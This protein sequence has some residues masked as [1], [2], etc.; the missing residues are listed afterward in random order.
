M[1][2]ATTIA[3]F[4]VLAIVRT[5]P[6]D[7]IY[8]NDF[9]T[10]TSAAPVPS[11]DWR[12]VDYV[13]GL[14][15]NT[16]PAAP[17]AVSE[18]PNIQ[19]W[20]IKSQQAN[21][22][23]NA[24]V[25]D[26]FGN[27]AA[28]LGDTDAQH[29]SFCMVK[30]RLG[31]TFA[32][33]VVTVQFDFRPPA[34]WGAYPGNRRATLS[35]GDEGFY[36]PDVAQAKVY[37]H[38]VGSVGV[39]LVTGSGRRAYWNADKDNANTSPSDKA[40][41][42]G[43]WCRAVATIDLEARTWGFSL[44][45]MGAHP[46][47]DAPT[48][49]TAVESQSNLPF[50]DDAVTSISSIA[51]GGFG[52]CWS[53]AAYADGTAP[54]HVAAFD[55]IRVWH[56]GE[57]C[58][59]NDF[60]SSRR[61]SLGGTLSHAYVADCLVTNRV[62]SEVYVKQENLVPA[63]ENSGN[64]VQTP[65]IDGW[66]RTGNTGGADN[67]YVRDEIISGVTYTYLR[68]NSTGGG[69]Q[70]AFLAHPFGSTVSSGKLSLSVDA[71]IPTSWS[72]SAVLWVTLGNDDY[73]NASPGTANNHRWSAVGI[74]GTA[75][76]PTF[77]TPSG[78]LNPSPTAAI[79]SGHWYRIVVEADLDAG[80]TIYKLYEQGT[81]YPTGSAADGTLIYT[82]PAIA[83]INEIRLISSFS[84]GAYYCPVY[85][86]NVKVWHTA[87]GSSEETLLY[88]NDFSNRTYYHQD[89][90]IGKLA[91]T[92]LLNPAGQDGWSRLNT[93]AQDVFVADG[94]NP[95]L[96]FA[97]NATE[98]YAVHDLGQN[99]KTGILTAQADI[100]PPKGW[101]DVNGG[102]YVRLGGDAHATGSLRADDTNFLKNIAEGFGFKR[103]TGGKSGGV[104]TNSTI[105]AY[106]GDLAGGGAFEASSAQVD[107]THWYR[108]VATADMP[109]S[110]YDVAV[111]DM[112]AA[113]PTL[114][115]ATP[116]TPVATF[117]GLPFR[118][119]KRNLGGV[120][121]V[122]VCGNQTVWSTADDSLQPL[123]DNIRVSSKELAFVL[124]VR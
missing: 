24:R 60:S 33:G 11:Q 70:F 49:A 37:D 29:V 95:A 38:T 34:S 4:S 83:K 74:R 62:G 123:V 103:T 71:R 3:A 110:A 82:S 30:Q 44:Y 85:F 76:T 53:G 55:N 101:L 39:V 41:T 119:A 116:E 16:N 111:Y 120:S 93:S 96:S 81:A 59:E 22:T 9:A 7:T 52:V 58:Y 109:K 105:V 46:A 102:V 90:H 61:R 19:D 94:P 14:L 87:S 91:G 13:T 35:F 63:R 114:A 6:A 51:L 10:R 32:S 12:S 27:H 79:S 73:Y 78:A 88:E 21:N 113:Q 56:N 112:G 42:Q 15:A 50:A 121:C 65:G 99:V 118:R 54:T 68:F 48:P 100:R 115:S 47:F 28:V 84:L 17:L 23:G 18:M 40:V 122:S 80:T 86:D 5:A 26:D 77:V 43:A 97:R 124:V 36:S 2:T 1:K 57:E 75:N 20:W 98:V 45:E 66:R 8:E 104:Y 89:R 64:S 25:Y 31:Q 108:F 92:I 69:N 107:P 106:R 67:A 117:A 72:S